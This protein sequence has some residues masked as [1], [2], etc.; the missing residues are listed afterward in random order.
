MRPWLHWAQ[1]VL[2]N[3]IAAICSRHG[4]HWRTITTRTRGGSGEGRATQASTRWGTAGKGLATTTPT[5][6]ANKMG[7]CHRP[8]TRSHFARIWCTKSRTDLAHFIWSPKNHRRYADVTTSSFMAANAARPE[9]IH[10][11]PPPGALP[12]ALSSTTATER[13]SDWEIL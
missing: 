13:R 1:I 5:T 12:D 7:L 8:L 10:S 3:R 9:T 6:S 4:L 2:A 11:H